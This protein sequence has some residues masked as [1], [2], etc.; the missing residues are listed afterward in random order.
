MDRGGGIIAGTKFRKSQH[1]EEHHRQEIERVLDRQQ[2]YSQ[3]VGDITALLQ[4]NVNNPLAVIAVTTQG[5]SQAVRKGRR[6]H[7]LG[8][9]VSTAPCTAHPS[10]HSRPPGVRITETY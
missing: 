8:S 7:A 4:D 5:N 6:D 1:K 10:Y 3:L 9:T 2:M